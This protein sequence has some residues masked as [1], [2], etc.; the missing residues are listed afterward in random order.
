M[1]VVDAEYAAFCARLRTAPFATP[2]LNLPP[3]L[4]HITFQVTSKKAF[5]TWQ[6]MGSLKP[7][8]VGQT[9]QDGQKAKIKWSKVDPFPALWVLLRYRCRFAD[10]PNFAR[11]WGKWGYF[12]G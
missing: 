5:F 11:K 9:N 1:L 10:L 7:F 8:I 3:G 4:T 12:G 2:C 6:P